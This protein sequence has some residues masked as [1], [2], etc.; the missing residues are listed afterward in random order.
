MLEVMESHP[1]ADETLPMLTFVAASGNRVEVTPMM[2][3]RRD[4]QC[5]VVIRAKWAAKPSEADSAELKGFLDR[6][7]GRMKPMELPG[8]GVPLTKED[9]DEV[10]VRALM[11]D[12]DLH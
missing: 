10:V 5:N 8:A 3:R 2:R 6:F 12:D 11:K 1:V 4:G 9:A 7:V